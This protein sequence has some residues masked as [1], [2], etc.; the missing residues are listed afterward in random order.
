M[1]AELLADEQVKSR[2][3]LEAVFATFDAERRSR[4]Q[5][6]V[7]SSRWIGD[8]YELCAEGVG[9]DFTK[10]EAQINERNG[11]IANVNIEQMC[12]R[13]NDELRKRLLDPFGR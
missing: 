5:W 6:L 9:N 12:A 10:I 11:I 3:E 4:A 7:E 8:C 13:A 2:H 1:L